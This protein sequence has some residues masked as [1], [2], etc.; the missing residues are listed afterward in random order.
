MAERDSGQP[1][2]IFR[3]ENPTADLGILRRPNL[4]ESSD[5]FL[6]GG[7]LHCCDTGLGAQEER[8]LGNDG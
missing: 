2:D 8:S 1:G 7:G 4:V 5:G 6:R 3:T